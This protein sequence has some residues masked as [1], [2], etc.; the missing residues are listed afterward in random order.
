MSFHA[1]GVGVADPL[2][3]VLISL[4]DNNILTLLGHLENVGLLLLFVAVAVTLLWF[5]YWV[6][7]RR[8]FRA[9]RIARIRSRSLLNEAT[10]R[11]RE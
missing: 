5:T 10:R 2:I 6:L 11:G 1:T 8:L 4:L 3:A 7:L 9:W